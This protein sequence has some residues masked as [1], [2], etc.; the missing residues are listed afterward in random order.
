MGFFS[1]LFAKPFET[2][3]VARAQE[4]LG[5]GAV[6]VD[7][8]TPQEYSAGH[9]TQARHIPLDAIERRVRELRPDTAVVTVCKSGVRSAHAARML[10][11]HGFTVATIRG[12]MF[13][14][15]RAGAT[16]VAKGG[17]AGRI[18]W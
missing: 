8:R 13:A 14:W 5:E 18:L 4:L 1:R 15:Q 12:G 9:A 7:V 2:V 11:A 17:R 16:V 6:L 10:A 3:S